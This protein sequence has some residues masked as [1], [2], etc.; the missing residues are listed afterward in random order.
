MKKYVKLFGQSLKE[1]SVTKNLV[2]CGMMAALGVVLGLVATINIGQYLRIG[3]SKI[4][5]RIVDYTFGPAV[6]AIFGGVLDI[7]KYLIN[8]TGPFFPGFTITE[9][10]TGLI[11]GFIL[12][13]KPLSLQRIIV[14]EIIEKVLIDCILNT[15][16]LSSLYKTPF[17]TT[18]ITHGRLF[19]LVQ[20]PVDIVIVYGI[21][22]FI[23]PALMQLKFV[24][25]TEK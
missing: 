11:Y 5:N 8:P 9:I 4:P 16:W 13:R 23:G 19:K 24:P 1:L 14:A 20:L 7:L 3:F 12:Y 2:L 10:L 18:L 25:K 21:L 6:G 15:I 17:L 22:K